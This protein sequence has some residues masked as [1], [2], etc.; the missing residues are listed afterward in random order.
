M[1]KY[2][3]GIA[4]CDEYSPEGTAE[5]VRLAV[6]RAGGLPGSVGNSVLIKVNALAPAAPESAV[7]T[8][9]QVLRGII[10]EIR[11]TGGDEVKIKIADNPGYIY[12]DM[13]NLFR[14]TGMTEIAGME[15]VE[16]GP[17]SDFGTSLVGGDKLK[18]L[19]D[20]RI[21]VRYLDAPYCINAAKLKTH[22]ETEMSGCIKNIFGTSDTDTR[23]KAHRSTSHMRL[24]EAIV[25]LY[26]IRPPDFHVMDAIVGMEGDGPSHGNPRPLGW[27]L[28]GNNA[29]AVDWV[30][31]TIMCYEDPMSINLIK[32]AAKRGIGPSGRSGITLEGAGWSDLPSPGF[33][34]SSGAIRLLP[35]FL[36]G[37]AHGLVK[38]SPGL[39]AGKCIR[40]GICKKVC[41]VDAIV[42]VRSYPSV[43]S[44]KCVR[45][46]CCHEMCPTGAMEVRK[47]FFASLVSGPKE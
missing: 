40:C 13:T 26:S 45:C 5:A 41:P 7:T 19:T 12:T 3:V 4:R 46:L 34:H 2:A 43:D 39:A 24:A 30:A 17:L 31:C 27:V 47:N 35:T 37:L 38:I 22:V 6:E 18:V 9:P 28:A 42:D 20:A 33:K 23:K 36:R 32:A 8:H 1:E 15:G 14:V 16:I 21:S 25:D 44:K 11:R 10:R 29:L